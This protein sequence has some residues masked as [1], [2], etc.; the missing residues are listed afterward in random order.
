MT[1]CR[2][3]TL[4]FLAILALILALSFSSL[5]AIGSLGGMLDVAANVAARKVELVE[6]IAAG[7]QDMEDHAKKTQLAHSFEN[8]ERDH[9]D[10]AAMC[11]GCHAVSSPDQDQREFEAIGAK[12]KQR[13]AEVRP[14][15]G[16]ARGRAALEVIET[17]VTEWMGL[18]RQYQA[19]VG[20]KNFMAAHEIITEKMFPIL[21]N[22]AASTELLT[23]QQRAYFAESSRQ[24]RETAGRHRWVAV[25][26]LILGAM[27]MTGV[28][29]VLLRTS[30]DLRQ[31]SFEL[32]QKAGMVAEAAAEVS[33]SSQTQAQGATDQAGSLEEV[34]SSSVDVR[35]TA[36]SN[37]ENAKTSAAVSTQVSRS[38]GDA[39]GRLEQLMSAMR[40]IQ[41]SS[42]KVGKIIKVIDEIAF[43]TNILA[44]NAAVEAARAGETG[45]GFAVVADEVRT[46]AQRSAQAAQETAGLIEESI[47]ASQNGMAKLGDVTDAFHSL[48]Q[49]ADTVTK[50][51]GEVQTGSLA[52]AQSLEAIT[53][54]IERMRRVTEQ[55]AAGAMNGA[56][57]GE[58]LS[59]QSEALREIVS[60]LVT[61]VGTGSGDGGLPPVGY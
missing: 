48:A 10:D 33:A 23:D 13:I 41:A 59:D 11:S 24:A 35:S 16:D 46:L 15:I 31:L 61:I 34:S 14:L 8:L 6:Q 60:R 32:G 50:L 54:R 12:V 44:L 55:A 21:V 58:E 40:E 7:F 57:A 22:I 52:Q 9:K 5:S 36:H 4:S 19:S 20:A 25:I 27:V 30:K 2:K 1:L 26:L 45:L 56:K 18:Y 3:L 39:N 28:S 49:G 29:L 38:L 47:A 43:Q 42:T 53:G 37:V 51:A 17:G